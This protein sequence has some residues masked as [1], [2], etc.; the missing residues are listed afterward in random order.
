MHRVGILG[1]SGYAGLELLRLLA[2]H[3]HVEL[4]FA[5]SEKLAGKRIDALTGEAGRFGAIALRS[6]EDCAAIACDAVFLAVPAEVAKV[7]GQR[8]RAAGAKVIDLSTEY[9][10]EPSIAVYG[11]PE[12]QR[13]A[14]ATADYVANPGCYPTAATLAI[15]PL[16]RARA[17][18]PELI[19][20]A[21]SGVSGAG[22]RADEEYSFVELANSAKA[23]KVLNHQHEPEI[24]QAVHAYGG[25]PV[26]LTFTPHLIPIPRGILAT[27]YARPTGPADLTQILRDAY[28]N[29]RFVRVVDSPDEVS[30][31]RVARTNTCMIGVAA[32]KDRVVIVS[33]IDNLVKGAAGQAIQNMNLMLG[34]AEEMAL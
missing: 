6:T 23:Y 2:G 22:R 8:F 28:A 24:R 10:M 19:V 5:S 11:L 26:D 9:R 21:M 33:A 3:A 12:F 15:V 32:R 20:D 16:L 1:A 17:I 13:A 34:L 25:E 7:H 18:A 29:E 14:I 4:A 31:A 30:I 27:I